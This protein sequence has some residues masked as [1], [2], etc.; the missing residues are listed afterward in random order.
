MHSYQDKHITQNL[1]KMLIVVL[2]TR[3]QYILLQYFLFQW[4]ISKYA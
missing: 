1:D 4:I 2:S 3:I